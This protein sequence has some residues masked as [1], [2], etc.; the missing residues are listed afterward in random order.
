MVGEGSWT[1]Q[2]GFTPSVVYRNDGESTL[3]AITQNDVV[4][5]LEKTKTVWAYHNQVTGLYE[6][7][8]PN[9]SNPTSVVVS[10]VSYSFESSAAAYALSTTGTFKIGD[11]VTLLLGRNNTVAAVIDPTSAG[12]NTYGI[13]LATGIDSYTVRRVSLIRRPT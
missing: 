4:Y 2:L 1:S 5:Y 3:S 7:A 9:R 11:T 8:E 10:G 6:S 13:V 12:T